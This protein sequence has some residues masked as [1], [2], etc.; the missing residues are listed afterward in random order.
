MAG[1]NSPQRGAIAALIGGEAS[2]FIIPAKPAR[3]GKLEVFPWGVSRDW[4]GKGENPSN[5]LVLGLTPRPSVRVKGLPFSSYAMLMRPATSEEHQGWTCN[6]NL[7]TLERLDLV[8]DRGFYLRFR[9]TGQ[10]AS[11]AEQFF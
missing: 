3:L 1:I 8:G 10:R 5:V 2:S 9:L 11:Y 6:G 7:V 4:N